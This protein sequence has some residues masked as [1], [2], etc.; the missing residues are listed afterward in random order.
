MVN[1]QFLRNDGQTLGKRGR[2]IKIVHM[3]GEKASVTTILKRYAF[4][5]LIPLIPTAGDA[6]ALVNALLI[7][8][9]AQR[10]GHDLISGTKVVYVEKS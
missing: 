10:C 3:D 8:G 6:V 4:L 5:M 9:A 7:F 1:F 2:K